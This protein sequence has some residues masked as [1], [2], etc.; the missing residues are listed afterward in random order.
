MGARM[1]GPYWD[2]WASMA[3]AVHSGAA[4]LI[5]SSRLLT[6]KHNDWICL[7][8]VGRGSRA[9]WRQV[10]LSMCSQKHPQQNYTTTPHNKARGSTSL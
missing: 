9:N 2:I 7:S 10:G 3:C 4:W 8:Q 6:W 1:K 5:F